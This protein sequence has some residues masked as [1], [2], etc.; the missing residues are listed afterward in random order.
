MKIIE[1]LERKI[2]DE[3]EDIERYAKMA[4]SVRIRL[5]SICVFSKT[6]RSFAS[7]DCLE[8]IFC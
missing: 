5:S 7:R 6:S 8:A 3:V 4:A 1:E 2:S